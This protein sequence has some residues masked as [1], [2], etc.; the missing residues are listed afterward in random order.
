M[1]EEFILYGN[2]KYKSEIGRGLPWMIPG[3]C[4]I[5]VWKSVGLHPSFSS[6]QKHLRTGLTGSHP[7]HLIHRFCIEDLSSSSSSSLSLSALPTC[8]RRLLTVE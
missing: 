2:K 1:E 5:K 6:P 4:W 7:V 3:T 8:L